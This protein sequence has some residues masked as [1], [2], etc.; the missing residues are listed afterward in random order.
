MGTI[1][2]P[3]YPSESSSPSIRPN[4]DQ[5]LIGLRPN[6][7]RNRSRDSDQNHIG[8]WPQSGHNPTELW[9]QAPRPMATGFQPDGDRIPI[10]SLSGLDQITAK[11][12]L[13]VVMSSGDRGAT[14]VGARAR[15]CVFSFHYTITNGLHSIGNVA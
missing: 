14:R 6:F 4:H 11:I 3:L 12:R 15:H 2:Q 9:S 1:A 5:I 13:L 8:F 7:G 10:E